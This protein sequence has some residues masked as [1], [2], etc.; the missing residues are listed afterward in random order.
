[1]KQD[2]FTWNWYHWLL[3][4]HSQWTTLEPLYYSSFFFATLVYGVIGNKFC[5]LLPQSRSTSWTQIS[6]DTNWAWIND[7]FWCNHC[8]SSSIVY[9]YLSL[10]LSK[11]IRDRL[12]VIIS[13]LYLRGMFSPIEWYMLILCCFY[14]HNICLV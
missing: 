10:Y 13:H 14:M 9:I 11:L 5:W 12:E 7:M 4:S 6:W 8:N 2:Q 3:V 1:M